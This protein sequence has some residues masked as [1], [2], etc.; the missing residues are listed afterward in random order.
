[1]PLVLAGG[2]SLVTITA[3]R[4]VPSRLRLDGGAGTARLNG[5]A[6]TGIAGGTVLTEPGWAT[7]ANRYDI[8]APAGISVI[9]V[10][11]W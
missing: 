10:G 1:V 2:A 9:T 6:Y 4:G 8:E 7:A 3:P 11:T 5:Q